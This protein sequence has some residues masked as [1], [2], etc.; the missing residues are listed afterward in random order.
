MHW[1]NPD[2]RCCTFKYPNGCGAKRQ[3]TVPSLRK[4]RKVLHQI[5]LHAV[6]IYKE[7]PRLADYRKKQV[8]RVD[9]VTAR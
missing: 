7:C 6:R 2:I 5:G 3:F 4:W 8:L 1:L 9:L